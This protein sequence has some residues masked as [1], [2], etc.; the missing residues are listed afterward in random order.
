M[1]RK[2]SEVNHLKLYIPRNFICTADYH[3]KVCTLGIKNKSWTCVTFK[4][5]R[6][7]VGVPDESQNIE[8]SRL[9]SCYNED[10][11]MWNP[12]KTPDCKFRNP[13]LCGLCLGEVGEKAMTSHMWQQLTPTPPSQQVPDPKL[14]IGNLS[15]GSGSQLS[16]SM[17]WYSTFYVIN[18]S[19]S[20]TAT[21]SV[22][23]IYNC[24]TE[25]TL[26]NVYLIVKP[27]LWLV[28]RRI[29]TVVTP[30]PFLKNVTKKDYM[31][32]PRIWEKNTYVVGDVNRLLLLLEIT[33][34][35]SSLVEWKHHF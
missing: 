17:W 3:T 35:S 20:Y 32:L 7:I 8:E 34:D 28:R 14:Y 12:I 30:N 29:V 10:V 33:C 27:V 1:Y 24:G 25:D 9:H 22:I 21:T 18:M 2:C 15:P 13:V 23:A 11:F 19:H 6:R 4:Y 16:L 5:F 31:F 26:K